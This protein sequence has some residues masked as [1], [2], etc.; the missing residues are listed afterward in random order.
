[1]RVLCI[2]LEATANEIRHGFLRFSRKSFISGYC[3]EWGIDIIQEMKQIEPPLY[4]YRQES[5]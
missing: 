3:E 2:V 5:S 1:M 4:K